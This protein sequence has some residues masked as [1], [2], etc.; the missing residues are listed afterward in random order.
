LIRGARGRG[1]KK[2]LSNASPRG[3]LLQCS[4]KRGS[5]SNQKGK[6]V[7]NQDFRP[8][9]T[10][11]QQRCVSSALP[12][13]SCAAV[14][15]AKFRGSRKM[16]IV[17]G[18][19]LV[20]TF[21][22]LMAVGH[23]ASAGT[24]SCPGTASTGDREFKVTVASGDPVCL[25]FGT[26]N[27]NGNPKQDPFLKNNPTWMFVDKDDKNNVI[28]FGFSYTGHGTKIGTF[29]LTLANGFKYALGLKSGQG[30]LDPDWAVIELPLGTSGGQ[31][32]I[33]AG[34]QSLS[35][36]NL[37]KMA[38]SEVPLPASLPLLLGGLAGIGFIGRRR[39]AA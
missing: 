18:V 31:W 2:P 17:R 13:A 36:A 28:D 29:A 1:R 33:A 7:L 4:D 37:Y 25:A 11:V 39:R 30:Q 35:H 5:Q 16:S 19:A 38:V 9:P 27:I 23:A 12:E 34:S 24:V 8:D 22:G 10:F 20:A 32:Q 3:S 26:G 15:A 6:I 21:V 14:G